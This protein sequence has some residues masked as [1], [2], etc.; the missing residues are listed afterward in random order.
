MTNEYGLNICAHVILGLPG[1]TREMMLDTARFLA[2]LP[3]SGVKIHSLYI[4]SGTKLANMYQRGE[5]ECMDR[6]EYIDTLIDF[7]EFLPPEYV[8]QRLTG[9]P[10]KTELL[11]PDWTL[12][13]SLN[14]RLIKQRLEERDTWQGKRYHK[15]TAGNSRLTD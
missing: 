12:E 14:V 3:I 7:L 2:G 4:T 13:K 1:E 6:D 10:R 11:A 9:D 8:I 5:F 15:F